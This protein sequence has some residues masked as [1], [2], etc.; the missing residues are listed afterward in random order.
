MEKMPFRD[1]AF[2]FVIACHVLEHS[3]DIEASLRELQRV[4][5]AGY[6]EPPDAFFER[7]NP[8]HDHRLEL[9][10]RDGMLRIRRKQ[11]WCHDSEVVELYEAQVKPSR[12]W[13]DQFRKNPFPFHMRFFWSRDNGGIRY[14]IVGEKP[15]VPIVGPGEEGEKAAAPH[16]SMRQKLVSGVRAAL[17]QSRRRNRRID[18]VSLLQCPAC[19]GS[20]QRGAGEL[21]CGSCPARYPWPN[22]RFAKM[23]PGA[24]SGKPLD[25]GG[26]A[27]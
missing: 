16:L 20:L 23:L 3:L 18:L 6:I 14:E 11:A 2:D 13:A 22:E 19:S 17:T 8:Y 10:V 12:L 5:K 1:G 25:S 9:T 4:A 26:R 24:R 7:I 27:G 21:W 15:P